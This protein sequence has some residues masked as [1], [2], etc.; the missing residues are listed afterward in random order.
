[1]DTGSQPDRVAAPS[2]GGAITDV[3]G[4]SDGVRR[5][6]KSDHKSV[7]ERLDNIP[8]IFPSRLSRIPPMPSDQF[9]PIG[10]AK[11]LGEFSR[12]FDIGEEH[13]HGA[14]GGRRSFEVWPVS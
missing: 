14:V 6:W 8:T 7:T 3:L 13:R 2:E 9:H 12:A 11:V 1:M 5:R 4:T 10:I